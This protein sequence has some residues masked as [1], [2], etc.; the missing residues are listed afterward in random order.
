MDPTVITAIAM[1]GTPLAVYLVYKILRN[2]N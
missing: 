1:A 2:G